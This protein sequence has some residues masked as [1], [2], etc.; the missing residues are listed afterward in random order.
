MTHDAQ[1]DRVDDLVT[2]MTLDEKL[3]Q[4][5]GL[6]VGADATGAGV[7]PHQSEMTADGLGWSEVIRGG[8]GQLTRPYGSAPVDPAAG[9][10]SLAASQAQIVAANRFGIP[11]LVHE[12]CLA[13]FAAW[14]A[15]AYPVPLSWGASF[16]PDL[17][18]AMAARIGASMRSA[19][20]HQGLAPVLDVT[21]D[22][23]WGRTEETIGED[24]YLVGTVGTAYVRGLEGSGVVAT[25][26]HFAGYSASRAGRNLAPVSIGRR[27]LAD[28]VLPPFEMAV[29]D[30]GARSVM[31]SYAELDGVP[32]AADAG[33]LTT[34]L[35]D[36]WG[37]TGT[38]VADYFGIRFLQT[39]H[40]VAGSEA[41]AAALAL[42]AG[43]DVELP[44]VHC[45]GLPLRDALARGEVDE[46]LV[47]R[48]LRRVLT[49]KAELG[50]LD[51]DWSPQAHAEPV[52]DDEQSR[53]L[54]LRLAREAIVLLSNPTGALPLR[55]GARVALVGPLAD[56]PMAM[57]GC[58]SFPAHVGVHHPEAGLGIEIPTVLD[59]LRA[60]GL[61]V[62]HARG[63]DV[64]DQDRDGF[65]EAV[66][67]A[68][69]ADVCV[70]AVG[71]RAGL[72]GRGT[73]GEGCDATD[74]HLPG[75][76]ADLVRALLGTG[77]PVVLLLLTGRPYAIAPLAADAAAVVQTFFPGQRGGQAIAD[78]LTGVVNPS[79]RLPVSIP[80]DASGQPGTYLSAPLG[81]RSGVSSVDP[82]AAFPFGHGL[83]YTS[84]S[85]SA[86]A[87]SEVWPT[88]GDATVEVLVTNT[89]ERAGADVVQLYLHDPVAQVTRP[90]VRLVGYARV[91]LEPGDSALVTFTVPA[92]VTA[93]TGLSGTRIVEPG[94][95]ELRV[96]RSSADGSDALELRLT[97]EL[98]EVDHTRRLTTGVAVTALHAMEVTA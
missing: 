40:G 53:D 4:L 69:D 91:E 9:A 81:R 31:H 79:G 24:P 45:Y 80:A 12:E 47:D 67:A 29:R 26:K 92:D 8:L 10:R 28:V 34:L 90:V 5:V 86:R 35:R 95:V 2:G 36:T 33:L 89:G 49:Q 74:L 18:E 38:V 96:A 55:P 66:A 60:A 84:F 13:G 48:A 93:F 85:W 30:G 27:E 20:V 52:L 50:L 17:V 82:T 88:D 43:V 14:G 61:D 15:T 71:D 65:A 58:Y 75:V 87:T 59:G 6:W 73:S 70:V 94:D 78:V 64:T 62:T 54:A 83:S 51:P 76:Q 3:S 11:A 16:D 7:A 32:S 22:Y 46:A 68:R 44:S 39:L 77:T 19:G 25:L 97:G 56:D 98:R 23:R 21:R 37:F 41:E 1:Q 57:L 42:A 63:C 72:F